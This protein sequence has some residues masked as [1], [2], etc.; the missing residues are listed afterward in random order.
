MSSGS[1][2]SLQACFSWW[3]STLHAVRARRNIF[4]P[5][6][7]RLFP[8][9]SRSSQA[10]SIS[11]Y[12]RYKHAPLHTHTH[13]LPISL[14]SNGAGPLRM[15]TRLLRISGHYPRA[16]GPRGRL[17]A[18]SLC[19]SP[20]IRQNQVHAPS[21]A[22]S[23]SLCV[24]LH[25]KQTL[26]GLFKQ[27]VLNLLRWGSLESLE[28]ISYL[29]W[30]P[31]WMAPVKKLIN[32]TRWTSWDMIIVDLCCKTDPLENV[33]F[34]NTLHKRC[35]LLEPGASGYFWWNTWNW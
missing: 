9:G 22:P 4:T 7:Y 33:L 15:T 3:K 6:S 23:L 29:L 1:L 35:S 17:A 2:T 30:M 26:V 32:L 28:T 31:L 19:L 13:T 27:K 11:R 12:A 34:H 24:R 20:H 16:S 14:P 5:A 21:C 25:W 8:N 18:H 10:Y